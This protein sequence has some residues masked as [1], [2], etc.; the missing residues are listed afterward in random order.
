MA[1]DG[2][3]VEAAVH[4]SCGVKKPTMW[5]GWA[6]VGYADCGCNALPKGIDVSS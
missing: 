1:E 4:G 5:S 3:M 2:V 6:L